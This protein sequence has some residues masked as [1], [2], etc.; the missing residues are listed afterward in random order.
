LIKV[1]ERGRKIGREID[2]VGRGNREREKES[3]KLTKQW[4]DGGYE[5]QG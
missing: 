1:I 3:F 2:K 4:R 5:L